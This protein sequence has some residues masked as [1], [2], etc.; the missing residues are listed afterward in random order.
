MW[1]FFW[2]T[3]KGTRAVSS[4]LPKCKREDAFTP[5]E[6]GVKWLRRIMDRQVN[7]PRAGSE[8]RIIARPRKLR[9]HPQLPL[10]IALGTLLTAVCG[11]GG[12]TFA[13]HVLKVPDLSLRSLNEARAGISIYDRNDRFICTVHEQ[14]DIDPVALSKVSMNMRNAL[15]AVEDHK[16]Y[17]H[18]GVD[19]G[20]IVRASCANWK[21]GKIVEGASTLT[22]QLAKN[23]CLD[24]NDRT[25]KR[26]LC[27]AILAY[28]LETK[29]SKN[30]IL[31]TYLNEVYYGGGAHGV[32]RAASHYFNKHASHLTLSESAYLAGLVQSPSAMGAPANRNLALKRRDEVLDKMALYNFVT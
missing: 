3:H 23:L 24:K 12:L 30:K 2:F 32:E 11:F 15:L 18:H 14:R 8:T 5:V 19:L 31:E 7:G 22:Q 10:Y 6:I 27:E 25:Y 26:K 17:E 13:R 21:A 16:F 20:S 28:D 9:P 1:L 29:Y 4:R